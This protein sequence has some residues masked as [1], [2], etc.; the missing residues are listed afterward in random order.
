MYIKKHEN[1]HCLGGPKL[2]TYESVKTKSTNF[3][4]GRN[5]FLLIFKYVDCF[6]KKKNTQ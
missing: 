2:P 6:C 3:L 4:L 1:V 5:Y